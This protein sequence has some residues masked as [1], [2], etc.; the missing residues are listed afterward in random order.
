MALDKSGSMSGSPFNALKV[1]AQTVAEKAFSTNAF[2]EFLTIFYDNNIHVLKTETLQDYNTQIE[3]VNASGRTNFVSVFDRIKNMCEKF[4]AEDITTI[5]FTDGEDTCNTPKEIQDSI[6]QT[7][8]FL[9]KNEITSRFF[10]IGF[11]REHDA[12]LLNSIAT[13]GSDLGNFFYIDD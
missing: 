5:F 3:K 6:E 11:R 13:A 4:K 8:N 10:T 7:K 12:K 9:N 1:G 2:K